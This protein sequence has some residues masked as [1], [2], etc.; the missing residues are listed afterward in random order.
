VN[1]LRALSVFPNLNVLEIL[2][3]SQSAALDIHC[4][5]STF[6]MSVLSNMSTL[7]FH[8]LVVTDKSS[9]GLCVERDISK[10]LL[11][12]DGAAVQG[13]ARL[14]RWVYVNRFQ[15]TDLSL[16][17]V[18]LSNDSIRGIYHVIPS[19]QQMKFRECTIDMSADA[20]QTLLW[21]FLW[22]YAR[23]SG[24]N[25]VSVHVE[26]CGYGRSGVPYDPVIPLEENLAIYLLLKDDAR[27]WVE[28]NDVV[29][30]R[31]SLHSPMRL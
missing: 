28:L 23:D 22:N 16:Q 11:H 12:M 30:K 13:S 5:F 18:V 8:R 2:L 10:L 27:A 14:P 6:V 7:P 25:L 9:P 3:G 17:R 19:L 26:R 24:S 1:E 4:T 15:L 29:M 20:A 31:T 21:A